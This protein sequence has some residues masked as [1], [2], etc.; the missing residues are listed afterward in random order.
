MDKY[1]TTDTPAHRKSHIHTMYSAIMISPVGSTGERAGGSEATTPSRITQLEGKNVAHVLQLWMHVYTGCN[2]CQTWSTPTCVSTPTHVHVHV[3]NDSLLII[4]LI[5]K[6]YMCMYIMYLHVYVHHVHSVYTSC[7][8][9][10]Y[11][12]CTLSTCRNIWAQILHCTCMHL[13]PM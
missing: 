12:M 13:T 2:V 9:Y 4:G 8:F 6:I 11:S 10:T 3:C 1:T 7:T 5:T